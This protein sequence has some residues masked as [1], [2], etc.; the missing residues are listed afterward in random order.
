MTG[1]KMLVQ[2]DLLLDVMRAAEP[3]AAANAM[4]RLA[5]KGVGPTTGFDSMMADG[6]SQ[7]SQWLAA[8]TPSAHAALVR[9][10]RTAL[11]TLLLKDM[12]ESIM[13]KGEQSMFGGGMA[14]DMWRSQL[15]EQLAREISKASPNLFRLPE[16][17]PDVAY[18]ATPN[19]STPV[20][21]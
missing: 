14:A 12:I 18:A 11:Q 7:V 17:V 13:P 19:A 9:D 4:S 20:S 2:T 8:S 5:S 16:M 21:A 15:S 3:S 6:A 1:F 10:P